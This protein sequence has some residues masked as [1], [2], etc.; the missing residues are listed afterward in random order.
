MKMATKCASTS[1]VK[2][3]FHSQ[4]RAQPWHRKFLEEPSHLFPSFSF[5]KN[6]VNSQ[7]I[8]STNTIYTWN[9][10]VKNQ[11]ATYLFLWENI[12]WQ[13]QNQQNTK[14][15][16]PFSH[17]G[18]LAWMNPWFQLQINFNAFSL[19]VRVSK[20]RNFCREQLGTWER[21]RVYIL[22]PRRLT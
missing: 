20:E 3:R 12:C 6:G 14:V 16:L 8:S 22:T 7:S 17:G 13:Y 21:K 2:I 4:H 11:R 9:I 10:N 5:D 15:S 19:L 1:D 18:F